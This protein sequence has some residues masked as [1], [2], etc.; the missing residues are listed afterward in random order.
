MSSPAARQQ[1][2]LADL[3]RDR[4][5]SDTQVRRIVALL[6]LAQRR[7]E[8]GDGAGVAAPTPPNESPQQQAS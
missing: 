7:D 4:G 3:Y 2:T 5:L 1:V 8:N 6:R